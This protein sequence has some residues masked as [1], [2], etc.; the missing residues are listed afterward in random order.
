[1]CVF[2]WEREREQERER[3][4]LWKRK[5]GGE[6]DDKCNVHSSGDLESETRTDYER[7]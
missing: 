2:V 4:C 1:M 3:L 7:H 6:C 5:R